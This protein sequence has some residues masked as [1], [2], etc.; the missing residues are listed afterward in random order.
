[1]RVSVYVDGFNLYFAIKRMGPY[2]WVNLKALATAWLPPEA[3]IQKVKYFTARV[4]GS[5]DPQSPRRQQIYI[6]AIRTL[7]SI[8]IVW[9]SFMQK[10]SWRPLLNLPLAQ[11]NC[12]NWAHNIPAGRYMVPS[13]NPANP[14]EAVDIGNYGGSTQH[15]LV[16]HARAVR[17][18]F[19]HF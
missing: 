4:S 2:K 6:N 17:V 13:Q 11:R 15:V 19:L 10:N 3:D 9:G 16:P 1:M 18:L 5:I 12:A 8:E 7:P 14:E